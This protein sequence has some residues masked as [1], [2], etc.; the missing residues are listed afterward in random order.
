MLNDVYSDAK[1]RMQKSIESLHREL[2]KLR[3]GRANPSVVEKLM[4]PYYGNDTPLNQVANITVLDARTLSVSPWEK[5]M[6][7]AVEKA[8]RTANL[9]LNP[10]TVGDLIRIP[11]PTL[12]EERRKDL[13]KLVKNEGENARIA[14]R[15]LRRDS[16]GKIK[17]LEKNKD[18]S[19][20]EQKRAEDKVQTITDEFTKEVDKVVSAKE[21]ELMEI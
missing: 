2:A 11:L 1:H 18:I 13:V 17:D 9:G 4:V 7:A 14:I 5:S 12:T 16:I 20:D 19:E 10:A 8:I 15:N 21:N 3:T 6:V